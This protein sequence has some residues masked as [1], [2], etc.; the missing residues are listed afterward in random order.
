MLV[1]WNFKVMQD[2]TK[3][4]PILVCWFIQGFCDKDIRKTAN[5]KAERKALEI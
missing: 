3:E 1:S 5:R 2:T 4:G